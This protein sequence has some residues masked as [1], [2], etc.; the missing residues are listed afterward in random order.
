VDKFNVAVNEA[1]NAV[2]PL[3]QALDDVHRECQD[4]T[5]YISALGEGLKG[6]RTA[7][8]GIVADLVQDSHDVEATLSETTAQATA[9]LGTLK[10]AIEAAVPEWEEIFTAEKTALA[11]AVDLTPELGEKLKAL[12]EAAEAAT[13]GVL[14][15]VGTVSHGLDQ[16]V[17]SVE[18]A[19]GVGLAAVVADWRRALEGA[20]THLVESLQTKLPE[21]LSRK[22][23]E[24]QPR[25]AQVHAILEKV[26]EDIHEHDAKVEAY[27]GDERWIERKD[28]QLKSTTEVAT[29]L[30]AALSSLTQA[31]S[32]YEGQLQVAAEMVTEQQELAAHGASQ[33]AQDLLAVR[34]LWATFGITS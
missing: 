27:I 20:C 24:W 26:F 21:E 18:H 4:A 13:H 8:D 6:Y 25:I 33:L 22:E 23:H 2:T 10:T 9:G 5:R 30:K 12:A 7:L 31:V 3:V 17:E 15:W 29:S 14:E 32:N 1:A 34:G 11:G 28:E 19:V 16:A